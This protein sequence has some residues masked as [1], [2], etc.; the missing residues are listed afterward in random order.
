MLSW[1]INIGYIPVYYISRFLNISMFL[2]P[3]SIKFNI[4]VLC[5]I[6][7]K[8][9][10]IKLTRRNNNDQCAIYFTIKPFVTVIIN[11]YLELKLIRVIRN[12]TKTDLNWVYQLKANKRNK[13]SHWRTVRLTFCF[14]F[15]L[16]LCLTISKYYAQI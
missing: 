8:S 1:Y 4:Y 3:I 5:I 2:I 7:P 14:V 15:F 6:T 10:I 9:F 16:T 13:N 12:E 11:F